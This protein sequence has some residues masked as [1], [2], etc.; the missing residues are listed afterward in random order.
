M[1]VFVKITLNKSIN[2][3]LYARKTKTLLL[4]A[5]NTVYILQ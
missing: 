4:L 1:L 2:P 3:L 5:T